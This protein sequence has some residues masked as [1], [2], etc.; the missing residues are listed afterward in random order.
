MRKR[1]LSRDQVTAILLIAPSVLAI[2]IFV[3]GFIIWSGYA[4]FSKWDGIVEDFRW[5]GFK[6]YI[7][8]FNTERFQID[9]RNTIFFTIAFILACLVI[10]L[11]L[12]IGLDQRIRGEN[13]FRSIYLFPMAIS[14]IVTGVVW[15]WLLNP[16]NQATGAL[17]INLLIHKLGFRG[18]NFGWYTDPTI[19]PGFTIGKLQLLIPVGMVAVVLAA[20]WQMSGYTMAL[21]LAGLRGVPDELREAARVDGASEPQIYRYIILPMLQPIT[22]SA[23]IILG[24]ISMK[25]FDLVYAMTPGGGPAFVTDVPGLFM[26]KTVFQGNHYAEGAAIATIMLLMVSVLVIPYLVNS[27][28]TEVKA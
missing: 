12:A 9:I 22:L 21:Y 28:R 26:F 27:V 25:I 24:H 14:F 17:G 6:N 7:R 8:L 1:R 15:R 19:W 4:S 2:G 18:F 16:G 5:N 3:Y 20:V 11:F 23:V 13:I 10:G